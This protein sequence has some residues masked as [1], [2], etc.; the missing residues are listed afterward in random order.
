[1]LKN[2]YKNHSYFESDLCVVAFQ[3]TISIFEKYN[4]LRNGNS[5][6]HPSALLSKVE[7]EYAIRI[8]AETLSFIESIETIKDSETEEK[9]LLPWKTD[10]SEDDLPF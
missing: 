5:A 8:V 1:M 2:W 10:S 6:A 4:A 7:A 9:N 3:N